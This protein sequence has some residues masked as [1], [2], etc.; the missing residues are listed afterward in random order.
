[1]DVTLHSPSIICYDLPI[2]SY[3]I[4]N[5]LPTELLSGKE[6]STGRLGYTGIEDGL[7]LHFPAEGLDSMLLDFLLYDPS[8][9]EYIN[10]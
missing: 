9:A 1:M 10:A 7:N 4:F 8:G 2:E 6:V 5:L 3:D